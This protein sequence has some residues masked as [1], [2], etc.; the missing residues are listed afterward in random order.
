MAIRGKSRPN[1]PVGEALKRLRSTEGR[2][3]VKKVREEADLP[4]VYDQPSVYSEDKFEKTL[5]TYL[6]F[7]ND[8]SLET[9]TD[10]L[11]RAL[12]DAAGDD[13]VL[14]ASEVN[15]TM[16][17]QGLK[18]FDQLQAA[19]GDGIK[20]APLADRRQ[21]DM[22][23]AERVKKLVATEG[24]VAPEMAVLQ[25]FL[26]S[27]AEPGELDG[28]QFLGLQHLFASSMTMF[29]A[30]QELGVDTADTRLI[31]KIYSTNYRVADELEA[32]GAQVDPISKRSQV[33]GD[34]NQQMFDAAEWQIRQM[35]DKLPHPPE[36]NPKPQCLIIDD[37]GDAI[38]T[39]HEKF[40]EYAGY[41]CC[42]EQT[43]RGA[44]KMHEL[45]EK[46][47]LKCAVVNVAE[48]WAKLEHESPMIGHS[49]VL[50]IGRKLDRLKTYG[51]DTGKEACVVGAGSVGRETIDALL[52]RGYTV[53]VYDKDPSRLEGL[54]EGVIGHKDLT[55]A[56]PHAELLVSCVG[57]ETLKE[58]DTALLPDGAI[59][60]N[61][62]SSND[63]LNPDVLLPYS[64]ASS[65]RD[66]DGD[67]W[68]K[69]RGKPVC[70]GMGAAEAHSDAVIRHPTT[71]KEFL[72][73]NRG[74]VV[75]MTGER[76]P[77]PPRFIQLT[78]TLLFLGALAAKRADGPG[79][80]EVPKEWQKELVDRVNGVL[81]MTGESLDAPD[82][83]KR[84]PP[85]PAEA[86]EPPEGLDEM[87]GDFEAK[88]AQQAEVNKR[89]FGLEIPVAGTAPD[90]PEGNESAY[91]VR[92]GRVEPR[93]YEASVDRLAGDNDGF[94]TP[95]EAAIVRATKAVNRQFDVNL[96][97]SVNPKSEAFPE[98]S[99]EGR[100]HYIEGN[101]QPIE[102]DLTKKEEMELHYVQYVVDLSAAVMSKQGSV[103]TGELGAQVAEILKGSSIPPD[104]WFEAKSNGDE[105]D[106]ALAAAIKRA[107]G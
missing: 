60:V 98:H 4:P 91:G 29:H 30:L 22:L 85:P 33:S 107:L 38:E 100:N 59:L 71:Q 8:H 61:A 20:D 16:G 58:S 26:D 90:D 78:R 82:W 48:S 47:E 104:V 19:H 15:Q 44:R 31:G 80:I 32:E 97:V 50:E 101:Q 103:D 23:G 99:E 96:R 76:D 28:F 7:Q 42:V 62:A 34:F 54:P 95:A 74:F 14:T 45:E 10:A 46:G 18:F 12:V 65:V 92:F 79:L 73:V 66:E 89:R 68:T 2:K 53:H 106:Q 6:S 83:E 9:V 41:F 52:E 55:D 43:R 5:Q 21:V 67:M 88:T 84:D 81:A 57:K 87:L 37:G 3:L 94:I 40:P 24:S 69:F 105:V 75:N 93:S 70:V 35:I 86:K 49:V 39:L 56:L 17:A 63:E 27:V 11:G 64:P 51:V 36:K 77:I 102:R 1:M 25:H 72:M 13:G